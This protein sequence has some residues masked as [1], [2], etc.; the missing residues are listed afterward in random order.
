METTTFINSTAKS[1][2]LI[3]VELWRMQLKL[4]HAQQYPSSLFRDAASGLEP[5]ISRACRQF[6]GWKPSAS[7]R[8]LQYVP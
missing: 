3:P 4:W 6:S 8:E 2:M 5:R 1:A 7:D